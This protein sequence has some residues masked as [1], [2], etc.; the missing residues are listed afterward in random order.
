MPSA[1][2]G[3]F[4]FLKLTLFQLESLHFQV[5]GML[6]LQLLAELAPSH[7]QTLPQTSLR[8]NFPG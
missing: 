2:L 1:I 3:P 4:L 8:E 6:F 7:L 5:L